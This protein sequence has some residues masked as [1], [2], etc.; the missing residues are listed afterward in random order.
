MG[1]RGQRVD[2][3][4]EEGGDGASPKVEEGKG[5]ICEKKESLEG[6]E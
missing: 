3:G 5:P 2:G 1:G 6:Y 4:A